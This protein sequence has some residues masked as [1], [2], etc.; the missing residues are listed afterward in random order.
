MILCL[1]L[2]PLYLFS[3]ESS[4]ST[5]IPTDTPK[6]IEISLHDI[7]HLLTTAEI[8]HFNEYFDRLSQPVSS[9]IFA[10]DDETALE[11]G[12]WC[13]GANL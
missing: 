1:L 7:S 5:P 9:V 8:T 3:A 11:G 13:C 2:L 10:D 12:K 4:Y 6:H